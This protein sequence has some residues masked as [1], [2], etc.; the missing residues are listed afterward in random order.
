MPTGLRGTI[1]FRVLVPES[2]AKMLVE[3]TFW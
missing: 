1:L 2:V 3:Y